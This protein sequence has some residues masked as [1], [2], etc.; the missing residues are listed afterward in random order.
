M[1]SANERQK[2]P[3]IRLYQEDSALVDVAVFAAAEKS[4]IRSTGV[5]ARQEKRVRQ[6]EY[7][8]A[9]LWLPLVQFGHY[10]VDDLLFLISAAPIYCQGCTEG[11]SDGFCRVDPAEVFEEFAVGPGIGNNR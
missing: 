9:S 2:P 11:K 10:V 6:K 3:G 7:A 5:G 4:A 8:P 1:R